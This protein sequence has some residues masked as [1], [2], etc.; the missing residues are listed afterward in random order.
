[1]IGDPAVGV[2][3][4]VQVQDALRIGH[5]QRDQ[6]NQGQPRQHAAR[7]HLGS[8]ARADDVADA[9]VLRRDVAVE[10]GVRVDV[11]GAGAQARGVAPQPQHAHQ[12]PV[13]RRREHTLED[14][15][16]QAAAALAGHQDLGAGG[17]FGVG[18]LAVLFDDEAAAQRNHEQDAEHA[19][20]R[21]QGHDLQV[22]EVA[23]AAG[24]KDQRRDRE[25]R[26][27]GNRLARRAQRLHDVVFEDG[28]LAELFEHGN[29]QH[30]DGNRGRDGQA[31][32]Q[33]QVH[34]R[35][36]EQDAKQR[37]Q[38]DG[39]QRQLGDVALGGDVGLVAGTRGIGAGAAGGGAVAGTRVIGGRAARGRAVCGVPW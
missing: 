4:R 9:Q 10:G 39:A 35:G 23:L 28:A 5:I 37:A 38:D 29:R 17:A 15:F 34:R 36:P 11:L 16:G 24:Q 12:H 30:R 26:A 21:R 18:Q 22:L 32:P 13:A 14:L 19:A 3:Q 2:A 31:R 1:M 7:G 25:H 33:R 27:G 6:R 8:D 20:D